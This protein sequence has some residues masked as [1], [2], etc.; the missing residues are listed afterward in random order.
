MILTTLIRLHGACSGART[1][2]RKGLMT[3]CEKHEQRSA[4]A[5]I[6]SRSKTKMNRLENL[7]THRL[8]RLR[9]YRRDGL[10]GRSRYSPRPPRRL[11]PCRHRGSSSARARRRL[12]LGVV[13]A[14][15]WPR[16][17]LECVA[18]GRRGPLL[19]RRPQWSVRRE[20]RRRGRAHVVAPRRVVTPAL[21]A[22][23]TARKGHE[24]AR[25]AA[26]VAA[27]AAATIFDA[28]ERTG[29]ARGCHG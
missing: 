10:L 6:R 15:S 29:E 14:W 2:S 3:N 24:A 18:H 7:R 1:P 20:R 21:G 17:R 26:V 25:A 27:A 8:R 11:R 12:R 19:A 22:G 28:A 16:R 13:R 4:P 9:R 23:G 5:K